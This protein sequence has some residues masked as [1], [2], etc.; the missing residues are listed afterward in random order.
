MT[1]GND[2]RVE[3]V[4]DRADVFI[5]SLLAG[6]SQLFENMVIRRADED[7]RLLDAQ[8]FDEREIF[9]LR[10]Y[11]SGDFGKFQVHGLTFFYGFPILFAICEK[12]RLADDSL[13]PAQPRKQAEQVCDFLNRIRRTGLLAVAERSVRDPNFVRHAERHPTVIERDFRNFRII[14]NF[15]IQIGRSYVLQIVYVR[16]LLQKIRFIRPFQH[17]SVSPYNPIRR[18]K[19]FALPQVSLSDVFI[20]Q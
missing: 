20:V 6:Q 16:M 10:P 3:G 19:S 17:K 14:V 18:A 12:F 9:L 4:L 7:S 5:E 13:L 1:A 11:P 15:R 8:T 2:S